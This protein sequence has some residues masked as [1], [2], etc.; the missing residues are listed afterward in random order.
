[1]FF[2]IISRCGKLTFMLVFQTLNSFSEKM[3]NFAM[4]QSF[5]DTSGDVDLS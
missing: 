4:A 3:V 1:M 2:V 5:K